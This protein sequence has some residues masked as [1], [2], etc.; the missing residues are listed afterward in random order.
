MQFRLL[1]NYTIILGGDS[2]SAEVIEFDTEELK[3]NVI[4]NMSKPRYHHAASLVS[5]DLAQ[6]CLD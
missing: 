4:G 1:R 3:W 2:A 6:Y 5:V